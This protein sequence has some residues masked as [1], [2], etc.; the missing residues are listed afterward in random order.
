MIERKIYQ[1]GM[2]VVTKCSGEVTAE[3]LIK[4]EYWMVD[5]FGGVIKPGFCQIF[6]ALDA[7]H[8]PES[9]ESWVGKR[10]DRL[11]SF[12]FPPS[13][14]VSNLSTVQLE[15]SHSTTQ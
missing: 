2:L 12:Q 5:N 7:V 6:D 1:D 4:S 9:G 14:V 10:R 15:P 8:P 3:E 11:A 13:V